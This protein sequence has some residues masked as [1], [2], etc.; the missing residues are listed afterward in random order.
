MPGGRGFGGARAESKR[1]VKEEPRFVITAKQA[2]GIPKKDVRGHADPY[3]WPVL[4]KIAEPSFAEGDF[5]LASKM[6]ITNTPLE[7][8]PKSKIALNTADPMWE[9]LHVIKEKDFK[10]SPE[11]CCV[12]F[13]VWDKDTLS[14]DYIGAFSLPLNATELDGVLKWQK[15]TN[16]KGEPVGYIEVGAKLQKPV[17]AAV[18]AMC[19]WCHKNFDVAANAPKSCMGA[20]YHAA[21]SQE[22]ADALPAKLG[23]KAEIEQAKKQCKWCNEVEFLFCIRPCKD[24]P[25]RKSLD[26]QHLG[27]HRQQ[28]QI[29][30][31]SKSR[32]K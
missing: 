3:V 12:T 21:L 4:E 6:G 14:S 7:K 27:E 29:L 8:L 5:K 23:K 19:K 30:L 16:K 2:R 28:A 26:S 17:S 18:S 32:R 11:K 13:Y 22:Q 20:M 9:Y 1:E 15:L 10:E 31:R 24:S 25:V